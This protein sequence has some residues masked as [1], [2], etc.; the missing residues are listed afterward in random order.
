MARAQRT[1]RLR[2]VRQVGRYVEETEHSIA[3]HLVDHA[4]VVDDQFGHPIEIVVQHL[5]QH[6]RV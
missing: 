1:R 2:V 4:A 5:H 6:S 3:E